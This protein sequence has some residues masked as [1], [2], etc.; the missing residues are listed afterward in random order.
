METARNGNRCVMHIPEFQAPLLLAGGHRQTLVPFFFANANYP[1]QATSHSVTVPGDDIVVLHDDRP[2]NWRAGD[3]VALLMHGLSGCHQSAYMVRIARKLNDCGIRAFRMDHRGCGAAQGKCRYPYH[4][5]I[6]GDAEAAWQKVRE[7]CPDSAG[8]AIGFSLSGNIV[9]KALGTVWNDSVARGPECCVSVNAPIDLAACSVALM[10]LTN[11]IYE[12]HFVKFLVNQVARKVEEVPG[13]PQPLWK[14]PPQRM[15]EFDDLYTSRISGFRDVDDYYE[16][17]SAFPV[18]P[19]IQVPT[20]LLTSRDDPLVPVET[21]E[22]LELPDHV[23]RHI[24]ASGGHLGFL[25]RKA[26]GDRDRRWMDWRVVDWVAE[27]CR[28]NSGLHTHF[29]QTPE[30]AVANEG[31]ESR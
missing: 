3:P 2:D 17:A 27:H 8:A 11:R 26:N 18:I 5:G 23:H 4:A 25:A 30:P 22:A 7:L 29:S 1:Y 13:A 21:Y 15:R 14:T 20:L 16:R 19:E 12:R 28:P 9:L 6:V 10:K 31:A 24:S